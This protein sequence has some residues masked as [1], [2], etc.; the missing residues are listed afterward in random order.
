VTYAANMSYEV[1]PIQ[2]YKRTDSSFPEGLLHLPQL[3]GIWCKGTIQSCSLSTISIVG[4]R[5]PTAYGTV[6]AETIIRPLVRAGLVVVSGMA[7]GSDTIAHRV[8]ITEKRPT[9]AVLGHGL[10]LISPARHISVA[11]SILDTGGCI[12]SPY[13]P[14]TPA[15]KHTFRHRNELIA[16]LAP[17]TLVTEAGEKSGTLITAHAAQRLGRAV[18]VVP[19]DITRLT[20]VGITGLLQE[21]AE[22]IDSPAMILRHYQLQL[23]ITIAQ[24]PLRPALTGT[25]ADLYAAVS[26]GLHTIGAIQESLKL[27]NHII[28]SGLVL[29]EIDH[30]LT[31]RNATWHVIS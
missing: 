20:S 24:N 12:I 10:D 4:T 27:P 18:C 1:Y 21:G 28:R 26:G 22:A 30:Y 6:I 8:A 3:M 13:A 17:V 15:Q 14:G 7:L 5:N 2:Y 9:V 29:L 19:G 25:M 31:T 23:P 11:E 16:A